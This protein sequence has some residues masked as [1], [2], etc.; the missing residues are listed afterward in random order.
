MSG[1][2]N[3]AVDLYNNR[4]M[5]ASLS[6]NDFRMKYAGSYLGIIW[7]FI[8]PIMTILVYWVVFQVGFRAAAIEKVP[9]ILW[10]MSGLIPWFFHAEAMATAMNCFFE[11]S[12]LVKKVVFKISILP[13]VKIMSS[14]IVHLF[15]IGVMLVVF[16]FYGY[17]PTIYTLQLIYYLMC[18]L[19]IT[20]ALSYIT[21]SIVVFLKDFGQ[22]VS[23]VLQFGIWVTPIMWSY[24]MVA[25]NWQW[26]FKINPLY[27]II[28]GY[29]DSMFN[30][31]W[32]WEKWN[33]TFWFWDLTLIYFVLGFI[34]FKKLKP[35]FSDV[36]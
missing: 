24:S 32:F 31:I 18:L 5:I 29:R 13:V 3:L 21:S 34:I 23:I 6:Y 28:E 1:L 7:A 35:H 11:Y 19:I 22:I 10:L 33:E 2:K 8:Q 4:R 30:H 25:D 36:L 26:V 14:F 16:A 17:Y 27:Y 9:F 15:F 20:V 12:Y